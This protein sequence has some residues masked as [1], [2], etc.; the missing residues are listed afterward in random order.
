[1]TR[2]CTAHSLRRR[3]AASATMGFFLIQR[4]RSVNQSK[5]AVA[6]T[7][8]CF[9]WR[10][11]CQWPCQACCAAS[12]PCGASATE[13]AMA[14]A[15]WAASATA[16]AG[17]PGSVLLHLLTSLPGARTP[18]LRTTR[19]SRSRGS[20]HLR[21]I[22]HHRIARPSPSKLRCRKQKSDRLTS[23]DRKTK[24]SRKACIPPSARPSS[25]RYGTRSG[26][27]ART[28]EYRACMKRTVPLC[29]RREGEATL[30]SSRERRGRCTLACVCVRL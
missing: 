13:R 21:R 2:T 14:E 17:S 5:R 20:R 8:S 27:W 4:V 29:K 24:S 28:E 22:L 19:L 9:R 1:M 18:F 23:L 26:A 3:A 11:G 30:F 15:F 12:S 16:G 10:W 6:R 25:G 7:T